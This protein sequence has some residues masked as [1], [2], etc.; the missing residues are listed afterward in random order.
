[1]TPLELMEKTMKAKRDETFRE[2]WAIRRK[3]PKSSTTTEK[4]RR[5]LP[6]TA[7]G[8]GVRITPE[9][10]LAQPNEIWHAV[11][12]KADLCSG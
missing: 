11:K 10:H 7:K 2:I 5:V 1:V 8:R 6:P 3:W 4:G 9:D 12:D